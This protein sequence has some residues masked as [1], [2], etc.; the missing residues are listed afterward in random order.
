MNRD[1]VFFV[2]GLSFGVVAGYFTFRAVSDPPTED[3]LVASAPAPSDSPIGLEREAE[4]KTLDASEVQRL[5]DAAENDS[6]DGASR[7]ALGRL[8]LAA[9]QY[10]DAI[11]WFTEAVTLTPNDLDTRTQLALAYLNAGDLGKT[12]ETYESILSLEPNHPA[13]LL[14]LGRVKLYLQQDIDAGLAMWK[15]L[16]AV[17]PGSPEAESVRD[18]LDA[19]TA[20]HPGS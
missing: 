6:S 18:E 4:T 1:L 13:S 17:A 20:A 12:V 9:G 15:K 19:L 8:Y 16:I 3:A 5:R 14:G 2:F 7:K 10:D 11:T